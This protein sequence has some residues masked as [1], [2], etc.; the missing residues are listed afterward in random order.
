M[1]LHQK[2]RRPSPKSL[3]QAEIDDQTFC[4]LLD[5]DHGRGPPKLNY[6]H[7]R[8]QGDSLVFRDLGL[9]LEELNATEV[10]WEFNSGKN[11]RSDDHPDGGVISQ[12][13]RQHST[14]NYST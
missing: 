4:R 6:V 9:F 13:N 12:G 2:S 10:T 11:D 8:I 3:L 1:Y 5:A 7:T 14:Q